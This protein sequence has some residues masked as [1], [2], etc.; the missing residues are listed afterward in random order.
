MKLCKIFIIQKELNQN[1]LIFSEQNEE[2]IFLGKDKNWTDFKD[3]S[4]IV[5]NMDLI[6]TID[7]SLVHLAASMNKETILLLSKPSD[8]RWS[9]NNK[10]LPNW[11]DSL[12]VIRQNEKNSWQYPLK[13]ILRIL[14]KKTI[15]I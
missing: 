6:I 12:T 8:W 1:D 2:I 3:T 14:E 13:E 11:Y 9:E 5:E 7:T 15:N 10:T 4:A